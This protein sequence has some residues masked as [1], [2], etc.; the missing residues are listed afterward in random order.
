M[1]VKANRGEIVEA[2]ENIA[3]RGADRGVDRGD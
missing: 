1:P 3:G 2:V